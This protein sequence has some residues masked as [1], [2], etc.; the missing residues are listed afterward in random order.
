[1]KG[2]ALAQAVTLFRSDSRAETAAAV[3][4]VAIAV[5]PLL[6]GVVKGRMGG[7]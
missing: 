3:V 7:E 1:M 4:L 6:F 2:R 5:G